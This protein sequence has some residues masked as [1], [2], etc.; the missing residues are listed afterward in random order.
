MPTVFTGG[1]F[2]LPE[3]VRTGL[4]LVVRDGR[5]DAIVPEAECS[6]RSIDGTYTSKNTPKMPVQV[7]VR[8][9]Y[10][11]LTSHQGEALGPHPHPGT[12][13]LGRIFAIFG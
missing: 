5:I 7:H 6:Y 12:G 3:G 10:G 9:L 1:R 4:A 11:H 13:H 8:D 2:L